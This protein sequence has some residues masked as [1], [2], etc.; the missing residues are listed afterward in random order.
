VR[1]TYGGLQVLDGMFRNKK[2]TAGGGGVAPA[3]VQS[4]ANVAAGQVSSLAIA[5]DSSV[6]SGNLVVVGFA[7]YFGADISPPFTITAG[8]LTKTAGTSTVGTITLDVSTKRTAGSD[9]NHVAIFSVP[10]TGSG[11]LTL[12]FNNG[13][14]IGSHQFYVLIG[15]EVDDADV[16]GTRVNATASDNNND[17]TA[18]ASGN[19]ATGGAGI[20]F[21]MLA[22]GAPYGTS[23]ATPNAEFSGGQVSEQED[24]SQYNH[25]FGYRTVTTDTTDSVDVTWG[26][27]SEWVAVAAAYKSSTP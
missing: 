10:V 21:G 12:T 24:D 14:G 20:I 17:D 19:V 15:S 4:K 25:W 9:E 6:T 2:V 5:F 7:G 22:P 26:A 18:G 3:V 23:T 16:S 8:M 13:T 11:T 27:T 1:N